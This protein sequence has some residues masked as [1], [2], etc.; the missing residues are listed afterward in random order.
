MVYNIKKLKRLG[1]NRHPCLTPVTTWNQSVI[2]P[3]ITT[4]HSA[5][6]YIFLMRSTSTWSTPMERRHFQSA[7]LQMVS[8]AALKSTKFQWSFIRLSLAFSMI[9]RTTNTASVVPLELRNP[10]CS[11]VRWLSM[12]TYILLRI[13][14]QKTFPGIEKL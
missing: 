1:D 2:F 14:L 10:H 5:C 6:L 7:S 8:N 3:F 9:W 12:V 11:S 4:S 13:I